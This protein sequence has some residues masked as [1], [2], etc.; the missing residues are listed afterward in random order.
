MH[1]LAVGMALGRPNPVLL[2]QEVTGRHRVLP[3]EIGVHEASMIAFERG[4]GRAP[5]PLAH[6]LIG[7][8]VHAFGNT[9]EHVDVTALRQGIFHAQL[10]LD[11]GTP[12]SARVSDAVAIALHLD[13]PIHADDAVLEEVGLDEVDVI[14]ATGGEAGDDEPDPAEELE[15]FRR[16]LDTA[17]PEDFDP[18]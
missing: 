16:F 5:R 7:Q 18:S 14:Q 4:G 9:I 12:V 6:Q 17:T 8:I 13:V 10:V 3:V 15:R 2:L 1:V 11:A